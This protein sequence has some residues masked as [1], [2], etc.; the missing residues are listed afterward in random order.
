MK[1]YSI[2]VLEYAHTVE[3]AKSGVIYGAHN[4]GTV[5]LPYSYVLIKGNGHNILVDVGFNYKEYGKAIA[6]A[7]GAINWQSPKIV[8]SEVGLTPEDIDTVIITHAH[9]DHFGNVED[10]PNAT[11][12]MQERELVKFIWAMSLP[13]KFQ[14][15]MLGVDPSDILRGVQLAKEGRMKL[16]QGDVENFLPGIDI[17][18][19]YDTHTFGSQYVHIKQSNSTQDGWVLA[20]DNAYKFENLEGNNQDGA[21]NA[22]GL[23]TGSQTNIIFALDKMLDLVGSESKRVIPIHEQRLTERFPSR[24]SDKGLFIVEVDLADGEVS[25]VK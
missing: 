13:S 23:A 15:L 12:Y 14:F 4:Q 22:I 19:A 10:F 7:F 25:K 3:F 5:K 8:L 17:Y 1:D 6:D 18:S 24:V 16:L 9:F 21:L 20:G 11:F 2:W